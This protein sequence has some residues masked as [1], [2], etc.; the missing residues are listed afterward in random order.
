MLSIN[1]RIDREKSSKIVSFV[2]I[3]IEILLL[4]HEI[5]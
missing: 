2:E 1:R 3:I 4:K 5:M